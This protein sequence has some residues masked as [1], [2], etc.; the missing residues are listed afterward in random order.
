VRD[1]NGH[2]KIY[3][4]DALGRVISITESSGVYNPVTFTVTSYARTRYAYD[5]RDLLV[6]VTDTV[7][8]ATTIGYDLRGQKDRDDRPRHG[9]VSYDYDLAGNLKSQVDARGKKV[10]FYYDA[11]NRLTGKYYCTGTLCT[12]PAARSRS[13]TATT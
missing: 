12:Y 4:T 2:E 9:H 8:N 11:L 3:Q 13:R 10:W 5:P 1:E 6:A 7:G